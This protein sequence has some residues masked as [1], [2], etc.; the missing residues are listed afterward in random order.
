MLVSTVFINASFAVVLVAS[1]YLNL[2]SS[3]RPNDV[4]DFFPCVTIIA[5]GSC[6]LK[7]TWPLLPNTARAYCALVPA[8][9]TSFTLYLQVTAIA[10]TETVLVLNHLQRLGVTSISIG[11]C[12]NNET[13]RSLY[14]INKSLFQLEQMRE[15][16]G[17][18]E[19]VAGY[20]DKVNGRQ[21]QFKDSLMAI[22]EW[23]DTTSMSCHKVKSRPYEACRAACER[24]K[25]NCY[26]EG[27]AFMCNIVDLATSVCEVINFDN[28]MCPT[29]QGFISSSLDWLKDVVAS[30]IDN[31]IRMRIGIRFS[32]QTSGEVEDQFNTAWLKFKQDIEQSSQTLQETYLLVKNAIRYFGLFIIVAWPVTYMVRYHCASLSFDNKRK[33]HFRMRKVIGAVLTADVVIISIILLLDLYAT[34]FIKECHMSIGDYFRTRGGKLFDVKLKSNPKGY[35]IISSQ[36]DNHFLAFMVL[37]FPLICDN[38]KHF[39]NHKF[40]KKMDSWF[41]NF[42]T[43]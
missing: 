1:L 40:L 15:V 30:I 36:L 13:I 38:H 39:E 11:E 25:I 9:L 4:L 28:A 43:K 14:L 6:I 37:L 23:W 35:I 10:Y 34:R 22:V 31:F 8:V 29:F 24:A 32:S 3:L 12:L 41:E 27:F 18:V 2:G 17:G 33:Q 20:F 16:K 7:L 42:K 19:D 21:N 26:N 5:V